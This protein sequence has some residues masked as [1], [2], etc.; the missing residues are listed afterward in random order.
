MPKEKPEKAPE[1]GKWVKR[2]TY[3]AVCEENK[4]LTEDIYAL[5]MNRGESGHIYDRWKKKFETAAEFNELLRQLL[6]IHK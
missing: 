6:N 5:V 1:R 4:R 3:Q 2:S